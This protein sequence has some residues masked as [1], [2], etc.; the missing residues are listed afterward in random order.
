M[1][2]KMLPLLVAAS[3]T[4]YFLG[5]YQGAQRIENQWEE[6]RG[7]HLAQIQRLKDEYAQKEQV[8]QA[9]NARIA[10]ELV[11]A[12]TAHAGALVDLQHDYAQ[13]L[14]LSQKRAVAYQRQA[15]TGAA[16]CRGL[17]D[18]AARLDESL[19]EGRRL[20]REFRTTLGQRDYQIT[21]LG[22]Q[23]HNDRALLSAE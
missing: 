5:S 6:D 12:E 23:L 15:A 8:H 13:R 7:R 11:E 18:H 21:V 20:V 19:E 22:R 2:S 16:E 17:A 10:H 14:Q 1:F 3:T 4:A 9:E